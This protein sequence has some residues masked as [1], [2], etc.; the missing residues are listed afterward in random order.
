[1]AKAPSFATSTPCRLLSGVIFS[2]EALAHGPAHKD[3]SKNQCKRI[4]IQ[5]QNPTAVSESGGTQESAGA[6]RRDADGEIPSKQEALAAMCL[7]FGYLLILQAHA[8]VTSKM[9][10]HIDCHPTCLEVP[11]RTRNFRILAPSS[12]VSLD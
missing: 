5:N 11:P 8:V 2:A 9:P 7:L 10:G 3:P 6:C 4:V 12:N 1:M